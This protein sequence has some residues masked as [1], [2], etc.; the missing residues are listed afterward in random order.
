MSIFLSNAALLANGLAN[1]R[2]EWLADEG[3]AGV[4]TDDCDVTSGSGALSWG[5][6]GDAGG[7]FTFK[8]KNHSSLKFTLIQRRLL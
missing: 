5:S 8:I 6:G 1:T 4:D 3:G 7:S 2:A